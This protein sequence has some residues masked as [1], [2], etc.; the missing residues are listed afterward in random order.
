MFCH[1]FSSVN[2]S[3]FIY[4]LS[5]P[6]NRPRGF[7]KV[8]CLDK[9]RQKPEQFTSSTLQQIMRLFTSYTTMCKTSFDCILTILFFPPYLTDDGNA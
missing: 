5:N 9:L 4:L 2:P 6:L 3:F 7:Q 1:S 8:P